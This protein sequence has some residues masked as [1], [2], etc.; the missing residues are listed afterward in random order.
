M[1]RRQGHEF[2]L[3]A[4]KPARALRNVARVDTAEELR[5]AIWQQSSNVCRALRATTGS[6]RRCSPGSLNSGAVGN[7]LCSRQ[8]SG[9]C[10][11][12][13]AAASR[14]GNARLVDAT[15]SCAPFG[16]DGTTHSGRRHQFNGHRLFCAATES[17]PRDVS[18][19]AGCSLRALFARDST[20]RNAL[21]LPRT[22][23]EVHVVLDEAVELEEGPHC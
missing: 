3:L 7:A 6:R 2:L 9:C 12:T 18:A 1:L 15:R 21:S 5:M 22:V 23:P 13:R 4:L 14:P 17:G 8:N 16:H 20:A 10:I 19:G 11:G